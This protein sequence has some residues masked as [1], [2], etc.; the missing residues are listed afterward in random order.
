MPLYS[1]RCSVG[2]VH[3]NVRRIDD[4]DTPSTCPSCG[5]DAQRD[6][7][8]SMRVHST[9][10]GYQSPVLSRAL[11]VNP[12]QIDEARRQFPHHEFHPDGRMILRSHAQ[13]KRVMRE[14]GYHDK[15]GY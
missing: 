4:R 15:D 10:Q 8:E 7:V 12:N 9:D 2:H 11:G 3:D 14:L 6:A 1:Y 13:R 5:G